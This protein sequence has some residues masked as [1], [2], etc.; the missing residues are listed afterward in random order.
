MTSHPA[1]DSTA[2]AARFVGGVFGFVFAGIGVTVLV[3][4]WRAP[5]DD[6]HSPPL[7]FRVFASFIA[8]A[9]VAIGGGIGFAAI[10][11]GKGGGDTPVAPGVA[12]SSTPPS[13]TA[14]STAASYRCPH[15]SA[16]LG[17][18]ADVSPSGDVK[19]TF[20]GRWFNIHRAA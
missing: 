8:I 12:A 17:D 2:G 10:R 5:F 18:R 11:G 20:C 1:P 6:F 19:C 3:F 9:F 7:F 4:M 13:T 14:P 16:P 15:C